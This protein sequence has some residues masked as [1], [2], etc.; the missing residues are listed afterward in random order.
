MNKETVDEAIN[1]YVTERMTKGKQRAIAHF[2][3]YIYLKQPGWE[4]AESMRRVRGMTRYYIDLTR[5]T[6]N[7][8]KGPELAW[9]ATTVI[10]AIYAALLVSLEE[11]RLLGIALLSGALVNACY[12]IRCAAAKWCEL[13]VMLAIYCEIVQIADHELEGLT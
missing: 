10:I 7:P 4:I 2:L 9:L 12:L 11:Q 1:L 13:H 6:L 3:A 5:V 8:F